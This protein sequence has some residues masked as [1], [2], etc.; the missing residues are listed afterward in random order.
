MLHVPN[1]GLSAQRE[2]F[3]RKARAGDRPV[4][5]ATGGAW[6]GLD[7]RDSLAIEAKDDN[8][9]TDLVI[10]R[11]PFQQNQTST[12]YARKE[13]SGHDI[14]FL[15]TAIRLRQGLGRLIRREGVLNRR[16]WFM[17][18]RVHGARRHYYERITRV[19]ARYPNQQSFGLSAN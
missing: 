8:L 13:R 10:L 3:M 16:I 4:W 6:V 5:I 18:G 17:D 2:E 14:E 19:L 11:L 9:L 12:H 15:E 1:G 7:L